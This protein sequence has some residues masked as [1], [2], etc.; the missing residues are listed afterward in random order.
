MIQSTL[1][2]QQAHSPLGETTSHST[3]LPETAAKSLVIPLVGE[4]QG[5]GVV[6]NFASLRFWNNG[7]MQRLEE[8][9]EQVR[10][11]I[12]LSPAPS[13][14]SGRGEVVRREES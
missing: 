8:V 5:R 10:C 9:V 11:T 3:R 12:S 4:G 14:A 6:P 13:P 1:D 2:E 7:V